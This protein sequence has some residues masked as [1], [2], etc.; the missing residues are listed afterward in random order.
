M[1]S[2]CSCFLLSRGSFSRLRPRL[3]RARGLRCIFVHFWRLLRSFLIE[4]DDSAFERGDSATAGIFAFAPEDSATARVAAFL[5]EG[6]PTEVSGALAPYYRCYGW[7]LGLS[8]GRSLLR[9]R[10]MDRTLDCFRVDSRCSPCNNCTM[11]VRTM[12]ATMMKTSASCWRLLHCVS[13]LQN[14]P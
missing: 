4:R 5:V 7:L 9:C 3:L 13:R 2:R 11:M 6:S 10:R 8:R 12:M 1:L 14:L